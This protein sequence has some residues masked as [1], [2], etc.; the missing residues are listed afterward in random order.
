MASTAMQ[1]VAPKQ[2]ESIEENQSL[3]FSSTTS[4]VWVRG[5]E[6]VVARNLVDKPARTACCLWHFSV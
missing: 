6:E 4:E 5:L 3:A 1:T 2:A